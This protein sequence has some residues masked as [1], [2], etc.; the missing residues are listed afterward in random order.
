MIS[1][2][3]K[4]ILK[5]K[6]ADVIIYAP[7]GET[8][9]RQTFNE[10]VGIVGGISIIGTTGIVTPMS[11]EAIIE[12]TRCEIDVAAAEQKETIC[13]TPGKIGEKNFSV[14]FPLVPVILMSNFTKEA[15]EHAA[16]KGFKRI[17]TAGHPSK[18]CKILMGYYN[19]HSKNSPMAA[20][21]IAKRLG[22][23]KSFNTVEE[24]L[25]ETDSDLSFLAA[26]LADKL[27]NDFGFEHV[28][29]IFYDMK[30]RIKGERL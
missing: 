9:A 5:D 14:Q 30:G 19:T 2:N 29:V 26:E 16:K 18:L 28:S 20:D 10:K 11:V 7:E 23:D 1:E 12:T 27:E 4:K 13:L 6:G 25:S 24:I 8:V 15:F 21:Y 3:L 22:F 17:Y